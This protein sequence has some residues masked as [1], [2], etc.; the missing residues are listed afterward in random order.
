VPTAAGPVAIVASGPLRTPIRPLA[1][2]AWFAVKDDSGWERFEVWYL[3]EGEHWGWVARRTDW[4]PL[5]WN[6][7]TPVLLHATKTGDEARAFIECL[8]RES[9][10]YSLRDVYIPVP[11]PNSNTYVDRM[12]RACKWDVELPS[13]CVGK[14]YSELFGARESTAGNGFQIETMFGGVLIAD[15]IEVHAIGLTIGFG[16]YPPRLRLPF[17]L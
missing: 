3:D 4:G 10:N 9:K 12:L 14:D 16:I 7:E 8:R 2:H 17:Q 1:R 15:G 11:G 13:T 5:E 6:G